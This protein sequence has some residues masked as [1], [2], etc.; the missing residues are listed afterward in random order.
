MIVSMNEVVPIHELL[1]TADAYIVK[2]ES[3]LGELR[4]VMASFSPI[5]LH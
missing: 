5:L 2:R 3:D 4:S 1:G